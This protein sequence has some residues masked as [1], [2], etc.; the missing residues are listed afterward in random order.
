MSCYCIANNV[1]IRRMVTE[2][3]NLA[4]SV[5][6]N[7]CAP[8]HLP[9]PAPDRHPV[10]PAAPWPAATPRPARRLRLDK[11]H[12]LNELDDESLLVLV[13]GR[14]FLRH[15]AEVALYQPP[16]IRDLGLRGIESS[17]V[18]G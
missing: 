15:F 16:L 12:L 17:S 6:I 5:T 2:S 3:A 4:D 10:R 7:A 9:S 11:R 8:C 14:Q 13:A 1:T 18:H